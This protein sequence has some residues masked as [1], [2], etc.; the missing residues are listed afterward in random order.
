MGEIKLSKY[1]YYWR[2]KSGR[3]VYLHREVYEK[4]YGSIPKGYIVH[5]KD[6]DK[7]N[8]S[9][10]NLELMSRAEHASIHHKGVPKTDEMRRKSSQTKMGHIVS[11]ETREKIRRKLKGRSLSEETKRKMSITRTGKKRGK[12]KKKNNQRVVK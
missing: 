3:C 8:N 12:Y 11:Q 4:H 6:G 7:L 5:H 1:G 9:I 10:D 2:T